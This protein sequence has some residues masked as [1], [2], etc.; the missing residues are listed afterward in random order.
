M[1]KTE[2]LIG[3]A[4]QYETL[5]HYSA[6]QG[7]ARTSGDSSI[8]LQIGSNQYV[9]P[10]RTYVTTNFAAL[11]LDP[12]TWGKD[13]GEFRPQRWVIL[14]EKTGGE[15]L[16]S[17]PGGAGLVAW[18]RGP[19]VCPGKKFSQVEFVS[20]L[21]SMLRDYRIEPASRIMENSE[22]ARSRLL[23]AVKDSVFTV[24]PKP[25]RPNDAGLLIMKR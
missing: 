22:A 17:Q 18:S 15:G 8:P 25:R 20:V 1:G 10:P 19:R 9:V 2:L 14:D 13:A 6:V 12:N 5:R 4:W 23:S 21:A 11:H 3:C 16:I 24:T 7:L